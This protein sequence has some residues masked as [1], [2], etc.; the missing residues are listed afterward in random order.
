MRVPI[1]VH[2]IQLGWPVDVIF[3][4][5]LRRALGLE[6]H[7]R[8]DARRFL[9]LAV[10]T[11]SGEALSIAS[12]LLLLDESELRFYTERGATFASLRETVV[13]RAGRVLG[14]LQDLELADD[15]TIEELVVRTA[16][17]TVDVPYDARV[18]LA[19]GGVRAAS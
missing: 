9:P 16:R 14:Q 15:G 6:V 5:E 18:T 8:D 4:R 3:D 17:G 7:C 19:P 12:S 1:R 11:Q 2:G 10:A 13:E